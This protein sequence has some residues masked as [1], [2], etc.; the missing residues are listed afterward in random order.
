MKNQQ[1]LGGGGLA[2]LYRL[3]LKILEEKPQPTRV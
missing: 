1:S 2:G 3:K